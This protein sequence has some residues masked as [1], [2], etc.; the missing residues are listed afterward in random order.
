[1]SWEGCNVPIVP[2]LGKTTEPEKA[3]VDCQDLAG[4]A[5]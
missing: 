3:I 2:R 1:M 5:R 4:E